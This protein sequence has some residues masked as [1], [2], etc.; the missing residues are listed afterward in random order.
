YLPQE[1]DFSEPNT[2]L[3]QVFRGASEEFREERAYEAKTILT[4]LGITAFDKDVRLLSGGQKKRVAIASALINPSEILI[5][6]EPT[7]HI[8]NETAAWLEKELARYKGAVLMITHDRYFLDRVTNRI[9]ELDKGKLYAYDE[10]YSGY[11][12]R[13]AE[14]EESAAASERKRQSLIRRE[15]AWI[16]RGARAR[17]TKSRDRI[18]RFEQLTAQKGP[19]AAETLELSS[20][21]ARLGKKTIEI[22]GLRKSWDG[23]TYI[24]DFD[25]SLDR[26]DRIGIVG[27]NG[28]GKSTLLR[29][30]AGRAQADGGTIDIGETV[31]IGYFAQDC[32]HMDERQRVIDF[33]RDIAETVQTPDGSISAAQML[34]RFLFPGEKQWTPIGKL[35]GGEKRRLYLLS[36]IMDAP[37]ILLL[38]E[39]TNDLDIETLNILES[40]LESFQGA[41]LAVSHDRYFLDKIA[42]RIFEFS[43]GGTVR[44][45]LGNYADYLEKR[46]EPQKAAPAEP[47]QKKQ[48]ERPATK[49]KLSFK[50]QYELDHIE[51]E[52]T[53]LEEKVAALAAEIEKNV[54]DFVKLQELTEQKSELEAKLEERTERW[55][56]LTELAESM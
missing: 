42:S 4:Q 29:I 23:V 2:V 54:S 13:K 14:R 41:V 12:R 46:E 38:D 10:N 30:L 20:I 11:L 28:T 49:R 44:Q 43:E 24:R 50:E 39:P 32:G 36:V 51:D 26:N 35:S 40:Y 5:L 33:V 3:E 19:Q 31:R 47:K 48:A 8:D 6:D 1:P 18:E 37:N 22:K 27:R 17:G 16:S 9:L 53:A 15:L 55:L 34:E 21:A 56:E 52:I 7:N 25:L 45:Y